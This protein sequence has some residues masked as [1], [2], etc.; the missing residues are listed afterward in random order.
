MSSLF[1]GGGAGLDFGRSSV[2]I[3]RRD[4]LQLVAGVVTAPVHL[5]RLAGRRYP[6]LDGPS[7][8]PGRRLHGGASS[9]GSR[10]AASAFVFA[11]PD[12][13]VL[14]NESCPATPGHVVLP[15]VQRQGRCPDAD[16][17]NRR[18]ALHASFVLHRA[19]SRHDAGF[20][21]L[22]AS[23]ERQRRRSPTVLSTLRAPVV[24]C[25]FRVRKRSQQHRE[26]ENEKTHRNDLGGGC[27]R[28]GTGRGLRV[29]RS[30]LLRQRVVLLAP[31]RLLSPVPVDRSSRRA[32]STDGGVPSLLYP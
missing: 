9:C 4:D 18:A 30:A 7:W 27:R 26:S 13:V 11:L 1:A 19:C 17:Q 3:A 24:S 22:R 6:S 31:P 25:S 12:T 15:S 16:V 23:L 8:S 21:A 5:R 32:P 28:R 20:P 10:S 29:A 14:P 2:V